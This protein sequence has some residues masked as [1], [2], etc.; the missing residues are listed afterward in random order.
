MDG[1]LGKMIEKVAEKATGGSTSSNSGGG[2]YSSYNQQP[3]YGGQGQGYN[4]GPAPPQDLPY[5]WV[6]RWDDRDQRW[7]Y[8]N[9]Q[10]GERSWERP[11]G[12]SGGPS[13][14]ERS[15]GQPQTSYGYEGAYGQSQEQRPEHKD[16]SM[17]YGAAAGAAGLVGGA[18][19]MHEGEKIHEDWDEDKERIEQNAEDFPE[20]AA[21]WT[22]E[23]VGE[24]EAI[25]ENIEQRWD[26]TEDRIENKWDNAVDDVEDFPENA[27]EWT[28]RRVGEVEQFGDNIDNAYDEGRAEGRD[29]W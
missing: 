10:T 28:G 26:R 12:G 15:Y 21:R 20:D 17:M 27:A 6:A 3:S 2:G 29:D 18:I 14:G 7:F 19:L 25:P 22:G 4:S 24:V 16:H 1:F 8:V 9:E 13:Y 23:K 11:Y 5:P